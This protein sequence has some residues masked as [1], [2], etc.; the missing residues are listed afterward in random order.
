MV[1]DKQTQPHDAQIGAV[2]K[3]AGEGFTAQEIA[4]VVQLGVDQVLEIIAAST[5]R[6]P[7]LTP[8]QAAEAVAL[9]SAGTTAARIAEVLGRP[10]DVVR[11]SLKEPD[12]TDDGPAWPPPA[13]PGDW[14]HQ[15][16]PGM[17]LGESVLVR[18]VR[19]WGKDVM[20]DERT[21]VFCD[22]CCEFLTIDQLSV[23]GNGH[24]ILPR[25]SPRMLLPLTAEQESA[26]GASGGW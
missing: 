2:R 10:L 12:P 24:T 7:L 11:N 18:E 6:R 8:E 9:R 13:A 3:L 14:R 23:P 25:V 17:R 4:G 21:L 20:I 26:L 22:G 1:N 15:R 19:L 5:P 16:L